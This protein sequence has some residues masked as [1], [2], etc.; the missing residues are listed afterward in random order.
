[1]RR[2][3]ARH[4]RPALT[5]C[6]LAPPRAAPSQPKRS[7]SSTPLAEPVC[8]TDANEVVTSSPSTDTLRPRS[9]PLWPTICGCDLHDTPT[10]WRTGWAMA[11]R[12]LVLYPSGQLKPTKYSLFCRTR[13]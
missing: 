5:Y 13:L 8:R 3:R 10:P 1:M 9:K 11:L 6:H 2:L 7:Y 12:L 4:G